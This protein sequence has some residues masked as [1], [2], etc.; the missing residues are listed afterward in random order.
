MSATFEVLRARHGDRHKWLVLLTVMIGTMASILSS[1]IV[2][3]AI[4]DLSQHFHLGQERA[5]WV[6]SG[7]MLAMTLSMLTTPWLLLRFGLRRTYTVAILVLLT[8]GVLGG[9]SVNYSML[10][11]MRVLE[12]LASGILQ[13]IPAIVILRAFDLKE[14]GRALGIFGF[15][16]VLAPAIGPSVGGV[17]VEHFGWQSIFFVV[18]PFCLVVLVLIRR[19]LSTNSP[20]MGDARRFDW[21]GLLLAG[22][23]T[24]TVLNGLV[25]L[26]DDSVLAVAMLALS[27]V[28][29]I[30]FIAWQARTDAP[31]MNLKL[32][33]YRQFSMGG[34]V[35]FIYGMGLFG[36]T[37][38]LPVYLQMALAYSPS[39]AGLVLL[40][41]GVVLAITIPLAGKMADRYPPN[42]LVSI[43]LALLSLSLG[44]MALGQ[45][46]G[47]Y[48]LLM[49][50]A[51]IGRVGL[52]FVL[53]ALSLGAMRGVD[54][55]LIAQGASALN[56]LRQLGGAIG[57]SLVGIVLEWR[58][59]IHRSDPGIAPTDMA[60]RLRA[61]DETFFF[62]AVL[63]AIAVFAAWRM[64]AVPVT[65]L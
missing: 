42:V 56:F 43:G 20:L 14:Q 3:V 51:V 13:P 46:G 36:S 47:S 29:F 32:F 26:Q 15:G 62:V 48:L 8:G 33:G 44:L 19:Y 49:A 64:R 40:P 57:V 10:L 59:A 38:L 45:P 52:G 11:S 53:P 31:L 12:G 27:L 61:F 63:C 16:V 22:T 58:L 60:N 34:L 6:S 21:K 65:T 17:L 35:A 54:H 50:W 5:Q 37:Y 18:V 30:G 9:F 24:V 39:R 23:C 55:S 7:F 25:H 2:N 28:S 41:A 4:P 1:T